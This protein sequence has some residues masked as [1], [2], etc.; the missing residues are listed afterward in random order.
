MIA[1]EWQEYFND[2]IDY[3]EMV[4][5]PLGSPKLAELQFWGWSAKYWNSQKPKVKVSESARRKTEPPATVCDESGELIELET[6]WFEP[7]E[8]ALEWFAK[9]RKPESEIERLEVEFEG[10][11]NQL[12]VWLRERN[13]RPLIRRLWIEWLRKGQ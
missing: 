13:W 6:N 9:V 4:C 10:L 2:S 12:V 8:V 11:E 5:K 7:N 3:E 1:F